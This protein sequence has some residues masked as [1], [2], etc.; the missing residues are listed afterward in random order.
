KFILLSTISLPKK[1]MVKCPIYYKQYKRQ[2]AL[3]NYMKIINEVNSEKPEVYQLP[4][5]VIAEIK[6]A[7]IYKIKN[8]LK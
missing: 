7:I 5:E 6:I 8:K 1:I 4:S 3:N 2:T